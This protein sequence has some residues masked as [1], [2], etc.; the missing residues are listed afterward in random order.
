MKNENQEEQG[1]F[2]ERL[3]C[4]LWPHSERAVPCLVS[5]KWGEKGRHGSDLLRAFSPRRE[6]RPAHLGQVEDDLGPSHILKNQTVE[7]WEES[8]RK[9]HHPLL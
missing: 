4:S 1:A 2:E 5:V 8:G 3:P 9:T 7:R 6:T